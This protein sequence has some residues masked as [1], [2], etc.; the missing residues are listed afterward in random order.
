MTNNL[1]SSSN[2]INVQN[3]EIKES[4]VYNHISLPSMEEVSEFI[5]ENNMQKQ[6]GYDNLTTDLIKGNKILMVEK[7]LQG[8]DHILFFKKDNE[9]HTPLMKINSQQMTNLFL[10]KLYEKIISLEKE[11]LELFEEINKINDFNRISF[12]QLFCKKLN[13]FMV[14][15]NSDINFVIMTSVLGVLLFSNP[16]YLQLTTFIV[17]LF[18]TID[19]CSNKIFGK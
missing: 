17:L 3:Y 4:S 19:Y 1:V 2:E 13:L 11:N 15:Y 14:K 6:A 8:N 7:L 16:K 9:N 18:S 5:V 10:E 12:Y